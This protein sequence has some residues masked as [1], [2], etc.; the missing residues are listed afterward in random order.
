MT[1]GAPLLHPASTAPLTRFTDGQFINLAL[2]ARGLPWP[3]FTGLLGHP[4]G[5]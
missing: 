5:R 2:G 3:T 1:L 4:H